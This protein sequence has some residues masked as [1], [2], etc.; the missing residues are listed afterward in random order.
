VQPR[1]IGRDKARRRLRAAYSAQED[2]SVLNCQRLQQREPAR[3]KRAVNGL[4]V[5]FLVSDQ[6]VGRHRRR[7][8]K[9]QGC[10]G[11]GE[12]HDQR[13]GPRS[14]RVQP[15]RWST[16]QSTG[17]GRPISCSAG[18]ASP[19]PAMQSLSARRARPRQGWPARRLWT[20]CRRRQAMPCPAEHRA[21]IARG[22]A[23]PR[24][25]AASDRGQPGSRWRSVERS[26]RVPRERAS[27][28]WAETASAGSVAR[29]FSAA[30]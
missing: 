23:P 7:R 15:Q 25:G 29:P 18:N 30:R 26:Q 8:R 12:T 20:R 27:P 17:S 13:P 24:H 14:P 9:H 1:L 28:V 19:V 3:C 5:G 4:V 22:R 2:G 16:G 10:I 6:A 11:C 21:T